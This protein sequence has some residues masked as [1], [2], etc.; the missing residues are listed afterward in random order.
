MYTPGRTTGDNIGK[1]AK[2]NK[3]TTTV[4]ECYMSVDTGNGKC[5]KEEDLNMC[6]YAEGGQKRLYTFTTNQL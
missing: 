1:N 3:K 2:S 6:I 4:R 5:L